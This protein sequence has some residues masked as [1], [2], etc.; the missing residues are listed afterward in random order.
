MAGVV[1]DAL[2][3]PL[4]FSAETACFLGWAGA[5]ERWP[6]GV[7]CLS[8]GLVFVVTR[9]VRFELRPDEIGCPA[10]LDVVCLESHT[11]PFR[12]KSVV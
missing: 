6:V 1:D 8:P 10:N 9:R 5:H 3:I 12:V 4:R 2:N 11:R 7:G